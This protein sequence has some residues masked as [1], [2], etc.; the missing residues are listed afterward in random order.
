MAE[1]GGNQRP[2]V[3]LYR[4]Y[5]TPQAWDE[6]RE[7]PGHVRQRVKQL[8]DGLA[9][10]PRPSI[11]KALHVVDSPYDVRRA[12]LERWRIVYL[13]DEA[14]QTVSVIAVRKRPPYNYQDLAALLQ[15]LQ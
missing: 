4:V 12:R 6:L 5:I 15:A 14:D 10:E 9:A 3:S 11:S 1:L 8:V 7:L 13:V 2:A